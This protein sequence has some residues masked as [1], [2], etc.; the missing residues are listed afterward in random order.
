MLDLRTVIEWSHAL[1]EQH[2]RIRA[3]SG[4]LEAEYKWLAFQFEQ[5]KKLQL[6][7]ADRAIG[8]LPTREQL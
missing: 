1:Q 8:E 6:L 2:R 5:L 7:K 4:R 3:E